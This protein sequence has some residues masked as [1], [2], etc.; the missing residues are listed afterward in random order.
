VDGTFTIDNSFDGEK[1]T[2]PKGV[3]HVVAGGGGAS[4][5]LPGLE[6]T[7]V[8]LKEDFKENYAN[9]TAILNADGYSFVSM[10]MEPTKLAIRV[11]NQ[12]GK[13]ID[14]FNITKPKR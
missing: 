8:S 11:L 9:F 14:K 12:D 3:I 10:D 13:Q 1:N 2:N 5:Y 6:K 7:S 4:L